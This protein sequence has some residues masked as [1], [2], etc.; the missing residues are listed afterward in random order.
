M[1]E[2]ERV[3]SCP[4]C[5]GYAEI[6]DE[7]ERARINS[8]C[9]LNIG[10]ALK[11]L[12]SFPKDNVVIIDNTGMEGYVKD[13]KEKGDADCKFFKMYFTHSSGSYRGHYCDLM[14]E[15]GSQEKITTVKQLINVLELDLKMGTVYGYKGGEYKINE[16]TLLWLD[17]YSKARSIAPIKFVKA[18]KNEVILLTK[19]IE[20]E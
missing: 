19:F 12:H 4:F 13:A 7:I 16:N 20:D 9:S 18:E 1:N 11:E 5:G 8:S 14:L 2:D 17:E 6:M 15:I 3:K 10:N